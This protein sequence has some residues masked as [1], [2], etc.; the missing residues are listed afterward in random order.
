MAMKNT[1]VLSSI[2]ILLLN[3]NNAYS[4]SAE[5][6]ELSKK[7]THDSSIS[8]YYQKEKEKGWFWYNEPLVDVKELI[9]NER[10]DI[11]P[12]IIKG[13]EDKPKP[14]SQEWIRINYQRYLDKA[15]EN[16][17]DK[18]AMFD[19]L[20]LEKYIRDQAN[21]FAYARQSAVFSDP[22]LDATSSRPTANFGMTGMNQQ[23]DSNKDELL[24]KIGEKSGLFFFYRSDCDFCSKQTPIVKNLSDK[25]GFTIKAISLDGKPLLG[26]P[27][28]NNYL[29]NNGQAEKLK[30]LQVPSLFL[31]T[32]T[33]KV[34]SIVQ[35]IESLTMLKTRIIDAAKRT[36]LISEDTQEL[37]RPS[38]LYQNKDGILSGKL[39]NKK[40]LTF[41][42]KEI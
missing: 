5:K 20:Y 9:A 31:V 8:N 18:K 40:S 11:E 28:E 21:E 35:G 30:V 7:N 23:A 39:E 24:K 33:G 6:S 15:I 37:T 19:Y 16:P 2:F 14:L 32:D 10:L 12:T 25:F 29:T 22:Y 17:Q 4:E 27:W 1:F 3:S 42:D 38:N 36:N 26:S 34:T 13:N 41:K